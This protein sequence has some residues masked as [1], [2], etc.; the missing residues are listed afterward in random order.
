[1]SRCVG[2][3]EVRIPGARGVIHQWVQ[4]WI[5]GV[6]MCRLIRGQDTRDQRIYPPVGAGLD[7]RCR[8]IRGQD[9]RVQRSYPPVGAGLDSRCRLIRGQDTRG[10][11]I[12]PPVGAGLDSRCLDV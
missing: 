3:S 5:A 7:S 8:L 1:V 2:L 12:Y 10:Q 11:R 6:S 4:D 9:T